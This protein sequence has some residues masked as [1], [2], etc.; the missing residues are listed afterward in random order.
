MFRE[1][2][3]FLIHFEFLDIRHRCMKVVDLKGEIC[4]FITMF[5]Y[6]VLFWGFILKFIFSNSKLK[7]NLHTAYSQWSCGWLYWFDLWVHMHF[8]LEGKK[9][10]FIIHLEIFDNKNRCMVGSKELAF[11]YE[12]I[13]HLRYKTSRYIKTNSY[14]HLNWIC[15]KIHTLF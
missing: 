2:T 4:W 1:K 6:H 12:V 5:H 8:G 9:L 14:V 3:L 13:R 11:I 10:Y 7:F 15:N